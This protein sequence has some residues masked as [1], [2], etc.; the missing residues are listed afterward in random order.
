M[1]KLKLRLVVD[2]DYDFDLTAYDGPRAKLVAEN[3]LRSLL[4]YIPRHAC[5]EGM[6]TGESSAE[7]SK[8]SAKVVKR[9]PG[10]AK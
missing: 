5:G 1:A 10:R 7:V 9:I 6:F 8:W 3:E 2:V 4:E